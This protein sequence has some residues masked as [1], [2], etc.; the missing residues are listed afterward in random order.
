MIDA[1]AVGLASV[2]GR[3]H[4]HVTVDGT[5]IDFMVTGPVYAIEDLAEGDHTI[6]VSLHN[7]DHTALSPAA[8]DQVTITV[9]PAAPTPPAGV[10]PLVFIATTV[11]LIVVLAVVAIALYLWGRKSQGGT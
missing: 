5:T 7:N 10:D 9:A 1:E 2:P 8:S 6:E 11:S 4:Y 3:G